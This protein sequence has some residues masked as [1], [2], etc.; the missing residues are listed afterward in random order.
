LR[1]STGRAWWCGITFTQ[2]REIVMDKFDWVW[3]YLLLAIIMSPVVI[4]VLSCP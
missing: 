1:C 4:A 3:G 2:L